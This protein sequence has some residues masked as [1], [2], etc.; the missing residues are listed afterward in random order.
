[1]IVALLGTLLG[2]VMGTF[3]GWSISIVGRGFELGAFVMPIVPLLVI[4]L[5]AVMGALLASI[6]PGWRAAHLDVLQAI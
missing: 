6:R 4:G 3:F 1:L 5:L 2:L